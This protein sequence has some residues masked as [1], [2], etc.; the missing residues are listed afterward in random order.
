MWLAP[1]ALLFFT[2]PAD[3]PN[4]LEQA[5]RKFAQVYALVES[6]AADPVSAN[7]AIYEG[8]LPA[9]MRGLDPHSSFLSPDQM[10]QLRQMERSTSKGFGTVVSVLPGR[11]IIL[12]VVQGA[13]SARAGLAPGD[14]IVGINNIALGQ[15][16]MEQ[17][18]QVLSESRQRPARLAVRRPGNIRLMSFT[19]TPEEMASPSVDRAFLVAD[20]IGF[21]RATSFEGETGKQLKE[22]IDKLGGNGLKGLVLD[23]RNNG[24]GI[25][26][27]ALEAAALFLKPGQTLVTVRGRARSQ[28]EVKVP[29]KFTPY[30]FP[31]A[32][33]VNEKTASSAEIVTGALQDHDRARVVGVP[34]FGK[35]LVQSVY[36]LSEGA[37]VAV[38]TAFYFTPS[39]RSIQRPLKEGQLRE[40]KPLY[41][42]LEPDGTVFKSD[43]GRALKGGG[44]IEPDIVTFPSRQSRLQ[45]FLDANGVLVAFATEFL[46]KKPK[47][48]PEF[49]VDG[50]LLDEVQGFLSDR[51][52]R[53]GLAEW[54]ADQEWIRMRV[55]Q[56]IFNQ[57]LGVERGDEVEFRQDPAV[58][59]ALELLGK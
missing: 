45:V 48:T 37:G 43:A 52:I 4:D 51:N 30:Q 53:P 6:Q 36:P 16:D 56:E 40:G 38:T 47:I 11:V 7:A 44:G 15:L 24:G 18:V 21:V 35:G 8:A 31:I 23:L 25:V 20:G 10:E 34:T 39:G 14:E 28:E 33:L 26:A 5:V 22:A 29:E 57:S 46:A 50:K 13:P 27:S 41:A 12:Q 42:N 3:D 58:K 32:V 9:M 59:R 55:L 49:T 2:P 1:L 19:L 17:L 54:S